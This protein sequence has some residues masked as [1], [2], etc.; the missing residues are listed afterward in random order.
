MDV[1][2]NVTA[3]SKKHYALYTKAGEINIEGN[4]YKV[5]EIYANSNEEIEEFFF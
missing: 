5:M 1:K 3:R 4:A 2:G